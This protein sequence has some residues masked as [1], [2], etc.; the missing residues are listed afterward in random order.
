M[1]SKNIKAFEVITLIGYAEV[2]T[3]FLHRYIVISTSV[4]E[5]V[6]MIQLRNSEAIVEAKELTHELVMRK[7]EK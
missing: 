1:G 5:A 6:S 2:K 3:M 4:P 7:E